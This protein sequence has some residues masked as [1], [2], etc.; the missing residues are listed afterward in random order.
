MFLYGLVITVHV[1]VSITLIVVILLQAGRGGGLSETF[2]GEPG[3]T[4]FGAKMNVFLTRATVVAAVLFLIT[5][6]LLGIL[7]SRRGRS[8]IEL[9]GK[10]LS[11]GA[12]PYAPL[13]LDEKL[14]ERAREAAREAEGEVLDKEDIPP[15]EPEKIPEQ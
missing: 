10:K 4:I 11:P 2:G 3:Q 9:E 13:P 15:I 8:L 5:S 6:L 7:T 1:I 14:K 12:A